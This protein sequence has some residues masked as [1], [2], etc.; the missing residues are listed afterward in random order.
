MAGTDYAN[1]GVELNQLKLYRGVMPI[2]LRG[3]VSAF[4]WDKVPDQRFTI[5]V[6]PK[7][8][9]PGIGV[10]IN[11]DI[12]LYVVFGYAPNHYIFDQAIFLIN[13]L[14]KNR[15]WS[16]ANKVVKIMRKIDS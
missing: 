16:K 9:S 8:S 15:Q 14:R 3:K 5:L 6:E 11:N 7:N 2:V 1:L 10:Y 13:Y 4:I 12:Q